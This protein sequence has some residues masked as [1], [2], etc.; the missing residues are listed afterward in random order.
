MNKQVKDPRSV[1]VAGAAKRLGLSKAVVME[2][3]ATGWLWTLH[4]NS[5]I[6]I[7]RSELER[8]EQRRRKRST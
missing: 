6:L 4:G 7:P 5:E 8:F 3:V 1:T 2:L